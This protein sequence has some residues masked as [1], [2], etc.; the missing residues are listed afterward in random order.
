[1]IQ[2]QR[3]K[4]SLTQTLTDRHTHTHTLI[5]VRCALDAYP[6]PQNNNT[7]TS[8]YPV[9]FETWCA[10]VC[11]VMCSRPG[12]VHDDMLRPAHEVGMV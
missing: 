2:L 9:R 11:E 5:D 7:I 10:A 3:C 4:R 1:M 8:D 6:C 12:R